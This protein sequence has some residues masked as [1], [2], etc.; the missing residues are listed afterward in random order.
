MTI[1]FVV[2]L[3]LS[4]VLLARSSSRRAPPRERVVVDDAG[5]T[6]RAGA[7][8]ERIGWREL[9]AVEVLTSDVGPFGEDLYFLLRGANGGGCAVPH[10]Q[11]GELL[12]RLQALP[13]FDHRALLRA[14]GST[15]H[16]RFVCWR[17]D[18]PAS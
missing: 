16:A 18:Q 8:I 3:G 10:A 4:L 15:D 14:V 17:R 12:P 11:A 5:V 6:R 2:V 13:N 9:Q 1:V 7:F